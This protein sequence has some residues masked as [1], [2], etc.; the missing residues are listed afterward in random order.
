MLNY[1]QPFQSAFQRR[2]TISLHFNTLYF[3]FPLTVGFGVSGCLQFSTWPT[4]SA[5]E[6]DEGKGSIPAT[7]DKN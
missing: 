6:T 7:G 4:S 3:S 1:F 2:L 5:K